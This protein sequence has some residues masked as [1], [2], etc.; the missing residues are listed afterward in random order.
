MADDIVTKIRT[1]FPFP[2]S[3]HIMRN[4][5]VVLRDA[6]GKEVGLFAITEFACHLTGRLAVKAA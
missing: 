6:T 3:Q 4:G 1:E 2:W 5:I